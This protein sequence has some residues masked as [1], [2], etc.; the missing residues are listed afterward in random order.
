MIGSWAWS[1]P[2][3][4]AF[5]C[6]AP[7]LCSATSRA[8]DWFVDTD[9]S[10]LD[11]HI[12]ESGNRVDG[13]FARWRADI[14]F[15]PAAPSAARVRVEVATTSAAT[16]DRR[17][18]E[19]M[20]GPDWLDSARVPV[21]VFEADGLRP[22]GGDRFEAA[23]T[24]RLRDG[25]RPLTLDV[26]LAIRGDEARATGRGVVVRTQYGVGQGQWAGLNVVGLEVTV[27][28]EIVARRR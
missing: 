26:T 14:R 23:G 6:L 27:A 28:F 12:I 7:A 10:R 19:A 22:L 11:F 17:R 18:D 25:V 8:D 21:A 13:R 5:G 20:R 9:R 2:V 1:L 15:D 24:L 4:V 16:G 3:A